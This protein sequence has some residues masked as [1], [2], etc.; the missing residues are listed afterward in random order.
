MIEI[1]L[2]IQIRWA[3]LDPNFHVL[4]SKYYD[5]GAF[6]RMVYL[7]ENGISTALLTENN[8]GPILLKE[9][10]TFRRELKFEDKVSINLKISWYSKNGARWGMQHQ[11]FKNDDILSAT[12]NIE[13]AWM[14]TQLRKL[15]APPEPV[16]SLFENTQKTV[17]FFV[18]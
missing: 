9:D 3:D 5:F 11:I 10:C 17:D 12:I 7:T 1:N 16:I 2:P 18:K 15:T 8:I 4:H 6:C 14:D 13:G